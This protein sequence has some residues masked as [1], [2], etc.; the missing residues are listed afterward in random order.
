M[1]T[2]G[3]EEQEEAQ[4]KECEADQRRRIARG[5][6]LLHMGLGCSTHHRILLVGSGH[7]RLR[8][9]GDKGSGNG[10][11]KFFAQDIQNPI[12]VGD[13][14]GEA[15]QRAGCNDQSTT[16]TSPCRCWAKKFH[17]PH[18]SD[19]DLSPRSS[20]VVSPHIAGSHNVP[21]TACQVQGTQEDQARRHPVRSR[22]DVVLGD[23]CL[24]GGR[25]NRRGAN[26]PLM[27]AGRTRRAATH[28]F[29]VGRWEEGQ[30]SS[31]LFAACSTL[32]RM[33]P[34]WKVCK[35]PRPPPRPRAPDSFPSPW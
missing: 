11:R 9:S 20:P 2:T 29:C 32:S 19:V 13:I 28:F 18:Y 8:G 22:R 23:P 7:L 4:R 34:R 3:W 25:G 33:P 31:K 30:V 15:T 5:R 17:A 16:I 27:G 14:C 10:R 6:C 12:Q 1:L 21:P 24:R 35:H 26:L